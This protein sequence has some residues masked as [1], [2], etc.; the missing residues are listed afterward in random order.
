MRLAFNGKRCYSV[1]CFTLLVL[2][3]VGVNSGAAI[4]LRILAGAF[5]FAAFLM[6]FLVSI[7]ML[8]WLVDDNSQPE[9]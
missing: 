3:L 6:P 9:E 5:I 1:V 8:S 4:G 7:G 2:G